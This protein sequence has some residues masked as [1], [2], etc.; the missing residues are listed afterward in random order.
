MLDLFC[1]LE[2]IEPKY[3]E[4]TLDLMH[5]LINTRDAIEQCYDISW[6]LRREVDDLI[7]K[8]GK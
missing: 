4:T 1:A 2:G 3:S 5:S 8:I 7:A 6:G